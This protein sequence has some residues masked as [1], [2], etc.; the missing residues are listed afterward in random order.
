[1][2]GTFTMMFTTEQIIL[3]IVI[4]AFAFIFGLIFKPV[5]EFLG[6][7]FNDKFLYYV[8]F[9]YINRL[10]KKA[11]K[12]LENENY[13]P[14]L[15]ELNK[16]AE[17]ADKNISSKMF[18]DINYEAGKCYLKLAEKENDFNKY[19]KAEEHLTK[20]LLKFSYDDKP[21][22]KKMNKYLIKIKNNILKYEYKQYD[23]DSVIINKSANEIQ[24]S[25]KGYKFDS[26]DK[27]QALR[28]AN[29]QTFLAT[30]YTKILEK[31]YNKDYIDNIT[32][33]YQE[34]LRVYKKDEFTEEYLNNIEKLGE[35]YINN[36]P[37]NQDNLSTAI[38]YLKNAIQIY[39][40]N[41]KAHQREM[42][43]IKYHL[44]R[45][46]YRLGKLENSIKNWYKAIDYLNDAINHSSDDE[47]EQLA[48]IENT[49]GLCYMKLFNI[50]DNRENLK[51]SNKSFNKVL[52]IYK[53]DIAIEKI[54]IYYKALCH[55]GLNYFHLAK[56]E[57][58]HRNIENSLSSFN[59]A[60]EHYK[61]VV[62]ISNDKKLEESDYKD[63]NRYYAYNFRAKV[64][65]YQAELLNT[66]T[67]VEKA[68]DD[69]GE[70]R[71]YFPID[72]E[73]GDDCWILNNTSIAYQLKSEQ[74][75]RSENLKSAIELNDAAIK[76]IDKES[77]PVY[78]SDFISTKG[79]LFLKL[80]DIRENNE[81]LKISQ[82]AYEEA[83]TGKTL[84]KSPIE[85]AI[86][87]N[88]LIKIYIKK[89]KI[90][91]TQ[92]NLLKANE[93]LKKA[94]VFC[95]KIGNVPCELAKIRAQCGQIQHLLSKVSNNYNAYIKTSKIS[96]EKALEVFTAESF[97]IWHA[98]IQYELCDLKITDF[99]INY[100]KNNKK[101]LNLHLIKETI[102]DL[103][104]VLKVMEEE[105][106]IYKEAKICNKIA[107]CFLILASEK[108][109]KAVEYLKKAEEYLKKAQDVFDSDSS[110]LDYSDVAKNLGKLFFLKYL[111]N[112]DDEN[113][114]NEAVKYYK[115][116]LDKRPFKEYP[117][118][119]AYILENF[120]DLYFEKSRF[121]KTDESKKYKDKVKYCY[122]AAMSV[123]ISEDYI[124]DKESLRNKLEE[125]YIEDILTNDDLKKRLEK[126]IYYHETRPEAE[127]AN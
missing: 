5:L 23:F 75:K 123:F 63:K 36:M 100:I 66:R 113:L 33:A 43:R 72:G 35:F 96:L 4:P 91:D 103:E 55:I 29:L 92:D 85:N 14:A 67:S 87:E 127:K 51:K 112:S 7:K 119:Q 21:E 56:I 20:A 46:Y 65:L 105:G 18:H 50:I 47:L 34:S 88:K 74:E 90:K 106:Y 81:N 30:C 45:A 95:T 8:N 101:E 39:S 26:L 44:G 117:I 2:G 94:S 114:F 22:Y 19:K 124:H 122:E 24:K 115:E 25:L 78:Y 12:Q 82:A 42:S 38:N 11:R 121:D 41:F 27:K 97:P 125:A 6:E 104:I 10:H 68:L 80:S 37:D 110:P 17:L 102:S 16:A 98:K 79:D 57:T 32:N 3:Y 76:K 93:H 73:L 111:E 86:T 64:Y 108:K 109:D 54:I 13:K 60:F 126:E 77:H 48:D 59:Q 15:E 71:K 84:E 9:I 61:K 31:E 49:L 107:D 1:M 58:P 52:S 40:S 118:H 69:L 89:A 28:Y 99:R 70:A 116:S 53:S 120:G 62:N 83:L